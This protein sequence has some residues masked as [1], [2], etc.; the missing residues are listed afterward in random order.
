M[1][2]KGQKNAEDD[3]HFKSKKRYRTLRKKDM[4]KEMS[5]VHFPA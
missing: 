2:E 4:K 5:N 1:Q 3:H